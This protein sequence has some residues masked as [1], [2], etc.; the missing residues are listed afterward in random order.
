MT[1]KI[2]GS[3]IL[4]FSLF[5]TARVSAQDQKAIDDKIL[6]DYFAQNHI[7]A[8][9]TPSGLYYTINRKGEGE[10]AKPGMSV[11]MLYYGYTLDG[12]KFDA[13][14][15]KN[16][17]PAG[18]AFTFPLGAHRVIA[19]WDEGVA[20]L[21]Q[22]CRATLYLPSGLAYGTRGAGGAIPPNAVLAFD[23]E[24]VSMQ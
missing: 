6:N 13:N 4:L 16:Y 7:K 15:D 19:G 18:N 3:M 1:T 14:M 24:V 12:K 23:V 9:K 2:L 20:L 5:I 22:G 11:S 8:T 21:N 10:N 17:N